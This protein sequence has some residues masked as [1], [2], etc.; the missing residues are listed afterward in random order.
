MYLGPWEVVASNDLRCVRWQCS[1]QGEVLEHF[2]RQRG[3][4]PPGLVPTLTPLWPLATSSASVT[5]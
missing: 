5:G 1:Y 3:P 4:A 2:C